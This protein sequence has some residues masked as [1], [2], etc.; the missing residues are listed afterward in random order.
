M[1][2]ANQNLGLFENKD[3]LVELGDIPVWLANALLGDLNTYM[4]AFSEFTLIWE[5]VH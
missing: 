3:W 4:R 2:S 5:P 1:G